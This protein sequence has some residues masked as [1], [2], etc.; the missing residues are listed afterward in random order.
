MRKILI[1]FF[2][3]F[4]TAVFVSET[5][6]KVKLFKKETLRILYWN[7]QNGMWAGQPEQYE[8]F[9]E[10]INSQNPD[11]CIFAEAAQIYYDGT[12]TQMPNEERYLPAHWG[13]LCAR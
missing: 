5:S 1:T 8:S 4:I 10:W 7:I 12:N 3:V 6:A 11:I 2:T 13:E 9:V